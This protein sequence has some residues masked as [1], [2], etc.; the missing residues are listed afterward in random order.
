MGD[1]G[2]RRAPACLFHI[3]L[4]DSITYA[5]VPISYTVAGKNRCQGYIPTIVS[6]CGWLLMEQATNTR[7]IFRVSGSA[8]RVAELQLL[9]DTPPTYGSQ[10]DWTGYTI[11]DASNVLRRYLNHLPDPVITLEFYEKFRDVHR[12]LT[13]DKEKITAYQDLISRLPPPH[14]CLLIYLLH[15]LALFAHHSDQNLMDSKNLAS[16]FQPGV[17]SHPNHAMSPGEYMTSAAVLKFLIDNQSSF[18]LPRSNIDDDDDDE[19]MN[20]GVMTLPPRAMLILPLDG[21]G[22]GFFTPTDRPF[23]AI[24]GKALFDPE[25]THG[26]DSGLRRQLSLNRSGNPRSSL[27]GRTPQRSK[28][29]NSNS[30]NLSNHSGLFNSSYLARRRSSR[31]S[32]APSKMSETSHAPGQSADSEQELSDIA[33]NPKTKDERTRNAGPRTTSIRKASTSPVIGSDEGGVEFGSYL[34]RR[35]QLKGEGMLREPSVFCQT[36]EINFPAPTVTSR[37]TSP[38][39]LSTSTPPSH[40][41][42][43]VPPSDD[44]SQ[45]TLHAARG[46]PRPTATPPLQTLAQIPRNID[47]GPERM[48]AKGSMPS[49]VA[50]VYIPDP[51]LRQDG[52]HPFP[53]PPKVLR[54][55]PGQKR[56]SASGGSGL[57]PQGS[58]H[59][60]PKGP[61]PVN[62]GM[63]IFRA[64]SNPGELT[65]VGPRN[66]YSRNQSHQHSSGSTSSGHGTIEM[67]KGLFSSKHKDQDSNAGD[68]KADRQRK[69]KSQEVTPIHLQDRHASQDTQYS[70]DRRGVPLHPTIN[71]LEDAE[72]PDWS[73]IGPPPQQRLKQTQGRPSPPR[74]PPPPPENSLMDMLDPP[75]RIEYHSGFPSTGSSRSSSPSQGHSS[76]RPLPANSSSVHPTSRSTPTPTPKGERLY[77]GRGTPTQDIA[78]EAPKSG[79]DATHRHPTNHHQISHRHSPDENASRPMRS[80]HRPL[81]GPLTESHSSADFGLAP[82]RPHP[83]TVARHGSFPILD[84]GVAVDHLTGLPYP[85]K[86]GNSRSRQGSYGSMD[87]SFDST[88]TLT[89]PP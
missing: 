80:L 7:G 53:L 89:T 31:T 39:H 47:R 68:E 8:K 52:Y 21:I 28:S 88:T 70:S 11:H 6:K 16:V 37:S 9:F 58:G 27:P 65:H 55:G 4:V 2:R 13:D 63:P 60:D 86:R 75:Q 66:A 38:S 64:K 50:H 19:L 73:I 45:G 67:F 23:D 3:D 34:N 40:P 74:P 20:F 12:N 84:H 5:G 62:S 18:T 87:N 33:E 69:Y 30:S 82:Q 35:K 41:S 83:A 36:I 72:L 59:G 22:P 14:S 79:P 49:T 46:H 76:R 10:L 81:P 71:E 24:P 77:Q 29:T 85:P 54:P 15:L 32:K 56:S 48:P 44:D 61:R 17:I 51:P 78:W 26:L 25:D 42:T 43:P 1:Q 57:H